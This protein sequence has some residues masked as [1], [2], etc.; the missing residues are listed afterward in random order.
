MIMWKSILY[1]EWLK[2]KWIFLIFTLLG[3]AVV[4]S[5]FLNVQHDFL[6]SG[7][8]NYW[9]S[10]LYMGL[11]YFSL[12]K[13]VPLVIG[14]AIGVAQYFPETVN[15]RIKLSF[16]LPINEN[17]LLI[18]MMFCGTIS[19]LLSFGAMFLLFWVLSS[20]FF[21]HEIVWAAIVSVTPWFLAGFAIYYLISLIVLEPV[22]KYWILY[23]LMGYVIIGL[24]LES[25]VA[26]GFEPI[27]LKFIVLTI[28]FSLSSLFSAYRFRKGEM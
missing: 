25:S 2:L 1:K 9:Y 22:W 3:I 4:S 28:L 15:K 7:A 27:N 19:L 5:I 20:H 8:T 17:R 13:Y 26:G 14:I 18:L 23:G 11:Q 21:P 12:L 24:Y 6:F 16:H 10:T